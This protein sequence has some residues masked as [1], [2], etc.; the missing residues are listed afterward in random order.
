MVSLWEATQS[1]QAS[2]GKHS[3]PPKKRS[4]R[5]E[6]IHQSCS[7]TNIKFASNLGEPF[8]CKKNKGAVKV[9]LRKN[10]EYHFNIGA[11]NFNFTTPLGFKGPSNED[12]DSSSDESDLSLSD[13]SESSGSDDSDNYKSD[14]DNSDDDDYSDN[15]SDDDDYPDDH[16]DD[17]EYSDDYSNDDDYTDDYSNDEDYSRSRPLMDFTNIKPHYDSDDESDDDCYQPHYERDDGDYYTRLAKSLVRQL[18]MGNSSMD[19]VRS[20]HDNGWDELLNYSK[21]NYFVNNFENN[22]KY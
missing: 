6:S 21:R 9:E 3:L 7:Q 12:S 19:E 14:T 20:G 2:L 22:K 5:T 16:S 4:I 13:S 8:G 1:L 11:I 18:R 15:Y 17:D 10:I